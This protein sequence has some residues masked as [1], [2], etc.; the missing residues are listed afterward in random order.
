M[1]IWFQN[2][3]TKW[4][5]QDNISNAEA[6]EFK[7]VT[8]PKVLGNHGKSKNAS[9]DESTNSDS[10]L[11]TL[12]F[13]A[14]SNT[15]TSSD[16]TK[17]LDYHIKLDEESIDGDSNSRIISPKIDEKLPPDIRTNQKN[18]P[19]LANTQ[20][21][22]ISSKFANDESETRIGDLTIKKCF[23]K[24]ETN[25][26]LQQPTATKIECTVKE[27]LKVE[28]DNFD[29]TTITT[30]PIDVK[31]LRTKAQLKVSTSTSNLEKNTSEVKKYE[32]IPSTKES[33][34]VDAMDRTFRAEHSS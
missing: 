16:H 7:N 17:A 2:R 6:A 13:K 26:I 11:Q 9:G 1:K 24:R 30:L 22:N 21:A 12:K 33:T 34:A 20:L 32:K 15:S 28:D 4:K 25:I 27:D 31:T 14:D 29:K 3:R 19:T 10:L 23:V 5:K 8:N 18:D